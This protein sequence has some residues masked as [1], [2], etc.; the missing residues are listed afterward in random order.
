MPTVEVLTAHYEWMITQLRDI[1]HEHPHA[2][3]ARNSV[4][5]LTIT[6]AD[7]AYLGYID[8]LTGEVET[9]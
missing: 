5:N 4:G 9:Y 6:T 8:V 2:E 3:V 7:G 1:A